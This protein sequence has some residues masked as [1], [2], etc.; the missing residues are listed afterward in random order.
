M[1][2]QRMQDLLSLNITKQSVIDEESNDFA[3]KARC[4]VND[5]Y[6]PAI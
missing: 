2:P 5:D 1:F 3:S 4:F 6:L